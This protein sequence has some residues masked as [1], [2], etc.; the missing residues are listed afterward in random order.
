M[1]NG[2]HDALV[3]GGGPAGATVAALLARAGWSV[4]LAERK[5]FPRRKVCGEYLSA[6]NLPLLDRLG[7]GAAFRDM[8]GPA[9]RRVGLYAG[10]DMIEA[11][12]PTPVG[13]PPEWGRSLSRERLD[14]LL[15]EQ[16]AKAGANIRQPWKVLA[17]QEEPASPKRERGEFFRC[18]MEDGE[19]GS[20]AEVT[21]DTVIAAHGSWDPGTLMSQPPRRPPGQADLLG[22][23][24]HFT[25]SALR[26]ELMPLL[27]FP[28]GYGGMVHCEGNRVSLSCCVRRDRLQ[29][30][31]HD[32]VGD[33][34]PAVL[35]HIQ[36]HCQG[37]ALA[38]DGACRDGPW[39]AAGP[40]SPGRRRQ[41]HAGLFLVGNAAGEAHP[42]IA[43]G[44]SM[45]IQSAFLLCRHLIDWQHGGGRRDE[46]GRVAEAYAAE[47]RRHF[48]GR[49]RLSQ[50]LA[51][52]ATRSAAVACTV[53]L[54]RRFPRILTWFAE[55]SGKVHEV[56]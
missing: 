31:R 56:V 50:L 37:V 42:V 21:A 51:A 36:D 45:G 8:A 4:I 9:I 18:H 13:N 35:D 17:I 48:A 44:I 2:I 39:L 38:L 12:L 26:L 10:R 43:E 47:W 20:I 30:L 5:R 32:H 11:D 52:W 19:V 33:A 28:G 1:R 27:A 6:S 16:A 3:I 24:A 25:A 34:G 40:L 46:L 29:A 23:K 22:F 41:D 49:L 15:L 53:P 55:L 54:I 14:L 7:V